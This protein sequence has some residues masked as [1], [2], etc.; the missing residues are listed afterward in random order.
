MS[1]NLRALAILVVFSCLPAFGTL[2]VAW[3]DH[4]IF[5][6]AKNTIFRFQ[7]DACFNDLLTEEQIRKWGLT[8]ARQARQYDLDRCAHMGDNKREGARNN[9]WSNNHSWCTEGISLAYRINRD[10]L[11]KARIVRNPCRVFC[12]SSAWLYYHCDDTDRCDL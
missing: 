12:I 5:Q 9:C 2:S 11:Q 10:G 4:F 8:N 7:H 1:R 3:A 6:M